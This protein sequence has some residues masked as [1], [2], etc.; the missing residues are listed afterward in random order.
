M[1]RRF[2][3]LIIILAV[4]GLGYWKNNFHIEKKGERNFSLEKVSPKHINESHSNTGLL[5][6]SPNGKYLV[7]ASEGGK[8]RIIEVEKK[9][10][11]YQRRL[12]IGVFKSVS[13]SPDSRYLYVG[14]NSPDGNLY[15]WEL[16]SG[17][18]I[19][20]YSVG[21]DIGKNLFLNSFPSINNIVLDKQG[22][23]YFCAS[24]M[25]NRGGD[26]ERVYESRIYALKVNDGHLLWK[27][28]A[29]GNMDCNVPSLIT[30]AKGEIV[31]F[32]TQHS[33][34][35][36]TE[37]YAP[38]IIYCL[39]GSNG[40]EI[41]HRQ[42]Q[43]SYPFK[44]SSFSY[45]PSISPDGE[46]IGAVTMGGNISF[47]S[48]NG[49]LLWE[50]NIS[51]PKEIN[52]IPIYGYGRMT[53]FLRDTF[54]VL[55]GNSF[56]ASKAVYDLPLEHPN[57]NSVF[58]YNFRGELLWKWKS[59]GS[60]SLLKFTNDEKKMLY[61]VTKNFRTLDLS[62]PGVYMLNISSPEDIK[63]LK[64][65]KVSNSGPFISADIS[66][67]EKYLAALETPVLLMDGVTVRGKYQ[68]HLWRI[69]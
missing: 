10:I 5:T 48:K 56:D 20:Q 13:F 21:K 16:E 52:G 64:S 62:L 17:K 40:R 32:G 14:E 29:Q 33:K 51:V 55:I 28:P 38:G 1:K 27:F 22:N 11:I 44:F 69:K 36:G 35:Q 47:F 63:L 65:Y 39:Q 42:I 15:C 12:G 61:P 31:V 58:A 19:W 18:K 34:H 4:L 46:Y 37:K 7:V 2:L 6:F 30:D 67:D 57:S 45:G 49:Q 66:S 60:M 43:T 8:I 3:L 59:A 23:L 54:L 25:E 68:V 26:L 41:W 24:R 9:R 50:K 53:Y